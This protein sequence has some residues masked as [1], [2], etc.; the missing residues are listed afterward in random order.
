MKWLKFH[1]CIITIGWR[2]RDSLLCKVGG[3]GLALVLLAMG[4]IPWGGAGAI[5]AGMGAITIKSLLGQPLIAEIE[6]ATRDK[7]ELESLSAQLAPAEAHRRANIPYLGVALGLRASIQ[8]GKDGRGI[9][10]VESLKPVNETTLRLL[11]ELS[12]PGTNALREYAV[13]L[14]PPEMQAR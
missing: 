1:G 8:T 11:I 14:E 5:A 13:L 9:I 10:R 2:H 6:L 12:G 4:P 3:L 7:R